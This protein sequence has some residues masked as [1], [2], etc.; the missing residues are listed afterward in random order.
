MNWRLFAAGSCRHLEA[1]AVKGGAWRQAVFPALFAAVET[2]RGWLV[3]DTGYAP[4]VL[5]ECRSGWWRLY[6]VLLPVSVGPEETAA[7]RMEAVLQDGEKIAGVFLTHFHADHEGGL[8]DFPDVPVWA[9]REAWE[10]SRDLRGFA[11]LRA[12]HL[13]GLLPEDL[14]GRLR[15]L[16]CSDARV[17]DWVPAGWSAGSDVLGDGTLW[18]VP[19][20]GHAPGQLGLMFQDGDGG[21]VFLV[22]DAL[23]RI[24]WLK[25]G[26]GPRWPVWFVTHDWRALHETIGTLRALHRARPDVRILPFH[27]RETAL[28][29]LAEG[30]A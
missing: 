4:R 24:D 30:C 17:P 5:E 18:A 28:E 13:P 8:K 22:A 23:W 26:H 6:P 9:G 12:A 16:E 15:L 3:V 14:P 29:L 21:V 10:A 2:S 25:D 19:L 20:P 27:C 1:V 7:R 11:S